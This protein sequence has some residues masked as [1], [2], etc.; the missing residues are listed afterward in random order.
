MASSRQLDDAYSDFISQLGGG[1]E[2][3]RDPN[4]WQSSVNPDPSKSQSWSQH[5][6]QHRQGVSQWNTSGSLSNPMP[7]SYHQGKQEGFPGSGNEFSQTTPGGGFQQGQMSQTF[8]QRSS[9][10]TLNPSHRREE[11]RVGGLNP[12]AS[13]VRSLSKELGQRL[14][15]VLTK[16]KQEG[17]DL[18]PDEL[19]QLMSQMQ[20]QFNSS[21]DTKQQSGSG[22]CAQSSSVSQP[23]PLSEQ[24]SG[25]SVS[26]D[27]FSRSQMPEPQQ[28]PSH[29]AGGNAFSP[30]SESQKWSTNQGI[31]EAFS[32]QKAFPQQSKTEPHKWSA[33]QGTAD[34]FSNPFRSESQKWPSEQRTGDTFSQ[35]TLSESQRW[36]SNQ[37]A[38]D[39]FGQRLKS[40]IPP[41]SSNQGADTFSFPQDPKSEPQRWQSN[42]TMVD[43]SQRSKSETPI[44]SSNRV[45]GDTFSA[46][47]YPKSESQKWQFDQA[48]RSNFSQS[49]TQNLPSS[50]ARGDGLSRYSQSGSH[51]WSSGQTAGETF[52]QQLKFE[53]QTW[54]SKMAGDTLPQSRHQESKQQKWQSEDSQWDPFSSWP[55]DSEVKE[56]GSHPQRGSDDKY[57]PF[58]DTMPSPSPTWP[59]LDNT[60]EPLSSQGR[61]R[62]DK[63]KMP[64]PPPS[65]PPPDNATEPPSSQGRKRDDKR[66]RYDSRN[67]DKGLGRY[68]GD[69]SEWRRTYPLKVNDKFSSDAYPSTATSW[70]AG[71]SSTGTK[72]SHQESL[73][74]SFQPNRDSSMGFD[75]G[76]GGS[77]KM[78]SFGSRGTNFG[79]IPSNLG[80]PIDRRRGL[81]DIAYHEL[82]TGF[83]SSQPAHKMREEISLLGIQAL[84][85]GQSQ[86]SDEVKL[87]S[88]RDM[89]QLITMRMAAGNLDRDT[90]KKY[91]DLYGELTHVISNLERTVSRHPEEPPAKRR[92]VSKTEASTSPGF[93]SDRYKSGSGFL[94]GE[95]FQQPSQRSG[96]SGQSR[97]AAQIPSQGFGNSGSGFLDSSS[98]M[99]QQFEMHPSEMTKFPAPHDKLDR[100]RD[101]QA[102]LYN[103]SGNRTSPGHADS[104][105]LGPPPQQQGRSEVLSNLSQRDN[106]QTQQNQIQ[107]NEFNLPGQWHQNQ[108]RGD[109][110]QNRSVQRDNRNSEILPQMISPLQ[111]R[112]DQGLGNTGPGILGQGPTHLRLPAP[113]GSLSA[114][115]HPGRNVNMPLGG[116]RQTP[117]PPKILRLMDVVATPTPETVE[118]EKKRVAEEARKEEEEAAKRKLAKQKKEAAKEFQKTC[119]VCRITITSETAYDQHMNGKR[120]KTEVKKLEFQ[121]K[122]PILNELPTLIEDKLKYVLCRKEE[123]LYFC[124]ICET[125]LQ[126]EGLLE[127]HLQSSRHTDKLEKLKSIGTLYSAKQENGSVSLPVDNKGILKCLLCNI[128]CQGQV[129]FEMHIN[130]KKHKARVEEE[131]GPD[132]AGIQEAETPKLNQNTAV[133]EKTDVNLNQLVQAKEEE[134]STLTVSERL[135][136]KYSD[137]LCLICSTIMNGPADVHIA[138]K[139][140]IENLPALEELSSLGKIIE[141]FTDLVKTEETIAR[142]AAVEKKFKAVNTTGGPN[143]QRMACTVCD[144]KFMTITNI[145]QHKR[146]TKHAI[147]MEAYEIVMKTKE[148]MEALQS[149]SLTCLAAGLLEKT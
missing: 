119:K 100:D 129:N 109:T 41:W 80:G 10:A 2:D 39:Q 113:V 31:S 133:K 131:E 128:E 122:Y 91:H 36:S 42:Q 8:Y 21:F 117:Q 83:Q 9:T 114:F 89:K 68:G 82:Q 79:D 70:S 146:G 28:W 101:I 81:G 139:K 140:H 32:Q 30:R 61:K 49:E 62:D 37:A 13:D 124:L 60:T 38:G 104:S 65:W 121:K 20:Q 135:E 57:D 59:P 46:S 72:R 66:N 110:F 24:W 43:F 29:Q 92:Y 40:E 138:S 76:Y 71:T 63:C 22:F 142:A 55:P 16:N 17:K 134:V 74:G 118:L 132:I 112:N 1:N 50:Q 35:H 130:S 95:H 125:N 145:E 99:L 144:I 47:Q 105:I 77:L 45:S 25:K 53:S 4:V 26:Q 120:H 103:M 12:N 148:V 96:F 102:R 58:L 126:D 127:P 14:I 147:M 141:D 34:S 149:T 23:Q 88:A 75:Q 106:M 90:E 5:T 86:E 143:L 64:S 15:D 108:G 44:W 116:E 3:Q 78:Q 97:Q 52:S 111:S 51:N 85:E 33:S 27:S 84:G 7:G 73:G 136:Q 19:Q 98:R 18:T 94:D 67:E 115:E 6:G 56:K 87:K 93:N 137:T 54:S 11:E 48:P 107:K 69:G 123:S